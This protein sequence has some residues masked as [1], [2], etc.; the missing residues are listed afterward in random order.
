MEE[1]PHPLEKAIAKLGLAA[2]AKALGLTAPALRKWQR[3]GRLP[4]T[5]WTGE[6]SYAKQIEELSASEVTRADLLKPWPK[7]PAD[8]DS[9]CDAPPAA[10]EREAA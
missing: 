8:A 9:A 2:L 1:Q 4:R 3:A 10:D 5:E 6:T 7:W